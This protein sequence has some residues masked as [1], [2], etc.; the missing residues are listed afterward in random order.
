MQVTPD[1][2]KKMIGKKTS[3]LAFAWLA[4]L[5]R[6]MGKLD[7]ALNTV[8]KGLSNLYN[9]QPALLV[10]SLIYFDLERFEEVI[11]SCEQILKKDPFCIAAWRQKGEAHHQLNQVNERNHAYQMVH[12]MDPLDPFW[13]E[14]YAYITA[15]EAPS[16]TEENADELLETSSDKDAEMNLTTTE[17]ELESNTEVSDPVAEDPFS[18]LAM[19]LNLEDAAEEDSSVHAL[20]GSLDSVMEGLATVEDSEPETLEDNAISGEDLSFAFSSIFGIE[21]DTSNDKN[22]SP[23]AQSEVSPLEDFE[24]KQKDDLKQDSNR[25]DED[26]AQSLDTAFDSIFGE[27]ELPEEGVDFTLSDD[28]PTFEKS[29]EPLDMSLS[30]EDLDLSLSDD[31]PTFEKSAEP[32]DVSLSEED[33]DLTLSD[34]APTFEKSA[35]PL[36]VSLS[37]GDLD[38]SLSNDAPTFEKSAE[39][40]D[41]S[42]SEED[43]DLTLSD[44]APTFEKSAESLDVS[45]SEGDLDLSLSDDAPAFEKSAEPL[46]V[47]L[48]EEDLDLS[49]S[50]DAPAF[51]KSAE[52]LDV[53][54]SEEDLDLSL[55][56][57]APTFEKSAEPLDVNLSEEDLDFSLSDDAPAFEKSAE[58]LDVSLSEGD[59]DLSLSDDAP[60]F[61]KSAEPLED[62]SED[63]SL[64]SEIS[65]SFASLFGEEDEDLEV[66]E[67]E[68][69]STKDL[70]L[71]TPSNQEVKVEGQE[72][73]SVDIQE[74]VS[75][76][77]D[78]LF[79]LSEDEDLEESMERD[80]V[81]FLMS[82]DSDDEISAALIENPDS[83][84]EDSASD[85]DEKLKTKTLA[86]IH[87]E[88]GLYSKALAIYKDLL[89]KNP[90]D[91]DLETRILEVEKLV[92]EK[93]GEN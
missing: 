16:F 22:A 24:E 35:E 93:Y 68:L 15:D 34:D 14:E 26:T 18:D 87:V 28:A 48:S 89:D 49:L 80:A 65:S 52:P 7:D 59:L 2:L 75:G 47:N 37:E 40:L 85:I 64:E 83:S 21:E 92:N 50:D 42:L 29:A 82:G 10:R 33:L 62:E 86:E 56:D 5:E 43:L 77:F 9:Y 20:E 46:D 79:D 66:L 13:K 78:S 32:L 25:V 51:E 19:I 61:E 55:S 76:A 8:N 30:E 60:T 39:P 54:L 6:Q 63:D 70:N 90:G 11:E 84:L 88:Q 17:E 27:D 81:D 57:D 36:D 69:K 44:D 45:L 4:D 12:D 72:V 1:S 31:V 58:P 67:E 91:K 71:E 73:N 3:S 38:L 53:S 74:E 41:V 23:F